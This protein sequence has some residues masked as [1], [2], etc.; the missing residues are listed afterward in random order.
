MLH[1]WKFVGL[2]FPSEYAGA[3]DTTTPQKVSFKFQAQMLLI[4]WLGLLGQ[5]ITRQNGGK[6]RSH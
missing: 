1:L 6:D 5:T 3:L 4:I 2:V